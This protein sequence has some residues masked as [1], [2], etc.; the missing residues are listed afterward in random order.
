MALSFKERKKILKSVNTL[1][2]TPIKL[3]SEE[4]D[5]DEL[6]TV[7]IPKFKNKIVVK[8]ISPKLKSDHFKVKLDKFGTAVWLKINGKTKVDQII[9]DVKKKFGDEIQ[10]EHE[11]ITK[12]VFQLYTQGFISFKELN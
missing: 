4:V 8:L 5:K 12:F 6:V 7:I 11:R 1:D 2:L 10:E 3:Y 9:K